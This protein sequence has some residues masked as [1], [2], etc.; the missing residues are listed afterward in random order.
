MDFTSMPCWHRKP[1]AARRHPVQPEIFV[2]GVDCRAR[3]AKPPP[4]GVSIEKHVIKG[5]GTGAGYSIFSQL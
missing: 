4:G 1:Y 5:P 3:P 2:K